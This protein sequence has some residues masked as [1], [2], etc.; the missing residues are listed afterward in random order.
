M[1][2]SCYRSILEED[3]NFS[4]VNIVIADIKRKENEKTL[5]SKRIICI[6]LV[7]AI[8]VFVL[9]TSPVKANPT[10]GPL[11]DNMVFNISFDV[12][13][14]Y[15]KLKSGDVDVMDW[16]L[17]PIQ[18]ADARADPNLVTVPVTALGMR[19]FD[20]NTQ[21][22]PTTNVHF[23]RAVAYLVDKPKIILNILQGYAA[24][25]DVPL[26]PALAT[27]IDSNVVYPNYPYE[28]NKVQARAE[29]A[30]A[31]FT[32]DGSG[33]I[34]NWATAPGST[35]ASVIFV[36]RAD[37]LQRADASAMLKA[38]LDSLGIPLDWRLVDRS[39]SSPMVMVQFNYNIYSGGW[40]LS[41]DPDYLWSL[42]HS[43]F[44]YP[45]GANYEGFTDTL[46]DQYSE[47]IAGAPDLASAVIAT[48]NAED[49]LIDQVPTI[50]L[51]SAKS[52]F[53][54]RKGIA[55]VVN[56]EGVGPNN[57]DTW[58]QS[59]KTS[60]Y[61]GHSPAGTIVY[62]TKSD[63]EG[64]NPITAQWFWDWEVMN[65][66]YE[67]MLG[68]DSYNLAL[69]TNWHTE[70]FSVGTWNYPGGIGNDGSPMPAG[71][72]TK[73]TYVLKDGLKWHD[74]SDVTGDDIQFSLNYHLLQQA[75]FYSNVFY[76]DHVDISPA[77]LGDTKNRKIEVYENI[78]S[79]W[80]LH[81]ISFLP[82]VKKSIWQNVP[83]AYQYDPIG[84]GTT[85]GYGPWKFVARVPGVSIAL[86][87]NRDYDFDA[88]TISSI[89]LEGFHRVG[90]VNYDS[91]V[92]TA[93]QA[94]IGVAFSASPYSPAPLYTV[95]VGKTVYGD[96]TGL[97]PATTGFANAQGFAAT[98]LDYDG[99]T[100]VRDFAIFGKYLGRTAG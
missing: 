38:E 93:D 99:L 24:R 80:A 52:V 10:N 48:K 26:P 22:W 70:S 11:Y 86:T 64:L 30:L 73:L 97:I 18:I 28:Y 39:V 83:N 29:L 59:Y 74:G 6:A 4:S 66:I 57:G 61:T 55:G 84:Q 17:T 41:R 58:F 16:E 96:A 12:E 1:V 92:A 68:S 27:Y 65:R 44:F 2:K 5:N 89:D 19:E 76:T 77:I 35:G 88:T 32:F 40:S 20:L 3:L 37:D 47:Q 91:K 8:L 51:W 7:F 13:T 43:Q 36:A 79:V 72:A 49:R 34:N 50:P 15:L 63:I 90:D 54:Y 95:P 71:P 53:A 85:I 14:E 31:G 23:R 100:Y 45:N 42:Y 33:K 94:A 98:D 25:L 62:G 56:A 60:A 46:F 81:W 82:I 21:K 87:A 69:D 9:P 75:W 78:Q 67:G